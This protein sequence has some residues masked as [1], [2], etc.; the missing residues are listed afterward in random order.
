MTFASDAFAADTYVFGLPK[1]TLSAATINQNT[2]LI[3]TVYEEY[4]PSGSRRRITQ[5]TINPLL[6]N[7]VETL[8][9]NVPGT[10]YTMKPQCFFAATRSARATGSSC[11][12]PPRTRTRPRSSR[13][14]RR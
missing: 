12:S 5:C 8:A 10:V 2:S 9:P 14:I 7:G 13:S 4:A 3:A 11:T 1:M 6:R